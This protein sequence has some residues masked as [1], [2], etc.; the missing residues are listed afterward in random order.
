MYIREMFGKNKIHTDNSILIANLNLMYFKLNPS[1][2]MK[3]FLK[4]LGTFIKRVPTFSTIITQLLIDSLVVLVGTILEAMP[5]A[6]T[7][8]TY[9]QEPH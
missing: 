8:Q 4:R 9:L 3:T 1:K 6:S 7:E 5:T 2:N